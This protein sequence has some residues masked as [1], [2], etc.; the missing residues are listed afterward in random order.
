LWVKQ[1]CSSYLPQ[2]ELPARYEQK[3]VIDEVLDCRQEYYDQQIEHLKCTMFNVSRKAPFKKDEMIE[4]LQN[5]I[6]VYEEKNKDKKVFVGEFHDWDQSK[7]KELAKEFPQSLVFSK[8]LTSL[9]LGVSSKFLKTPN[10]TELRSWLESQDVVSVEIEDLFLKSLELNQGDLYLTLLSIENILSEYWKTPRRDQIIQTTR[11][12]SITNHC[13]GSKPEDVYGSWYHMFGMMLYGCVSGPVAADFVAR[14]E[15]TG[16]RILDAKSV[17][18]EGEN[19]LLHLL[20]GSDPQEEKIN[21][22]SG[23]VGHGLCKAIREK[24]KN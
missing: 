2:S 13:P 19:V 22:I 20:V 6:K 21:R 8:I 4:R 9:A 10:D 1:N 11:L 14:T 24:S 7:K 23:H 5:V 17:K 15:N 12:K 18:R 3:E 16:S